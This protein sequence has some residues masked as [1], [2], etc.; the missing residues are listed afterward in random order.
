MANIIRKIIKVSGDSKIALDK[1]KQTIG[2]TKTCV[3]PAAVGSTTSK[4]QK[5]V[6]ERK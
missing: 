1:L 2:G 6:C 3:K 4:T 5:T